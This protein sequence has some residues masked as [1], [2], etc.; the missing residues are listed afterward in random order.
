M[1]FNELICTKN[2]RKVDILNIIRLIPDSRRLLLFIK[3]FF[4]LIIIQKAI[5]DILIGIS[6]INLT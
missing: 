1:V 3:G 4:I 6:L 5:G 2:S